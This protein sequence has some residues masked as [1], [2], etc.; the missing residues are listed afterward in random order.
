MDGHAESAP[1][2][3]G[4]AD[5][6]SFLSD[7]P[8]EESNEELEAPN[9]DEPTAESDQGEPESAG[10]DEAE[11]GG[12]EPADEAEEDA[13]PATER[14]IAVTIKADDGTETTQEV[15]ESELVKGYQ[16]QAD[17]T[18][19][20]QALAERESQAVEF[21]KTKHDEVR[22]HYM[23]QAEV[24]RAAVVQMAGIKTESEM[25]QLA[26]T[27]PAA[28]VAES[29]RQKAITTYLSQLDQQING[30]KQAAQQ[31]QS[32]RQLQQRQQAYQKAWTELSQDGIDK[33]KLASIYAKSEKLYGF[34]PAELA[35]VYDARMVRVLKD[36]AAFRDL[37]SQKKAVTQKVQEAPKLQA[38]KQ[39]P[40]QERRQQE[41]DNRFR[42]G[43]AKLSDLAA[44]LT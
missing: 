20:T 3:G 25:A 14:K 35:E 44:Y 19:K 27:D 5:L 30:E 9:S 32:Q 42:S 40:A 36:A 33:P 39:A 23:Q 13:D 37:Q 11:E 18:R 29:Q 15:A 26:Q 43:K 41:L 1:E 22:S 31:E 12:D 21:L 24:T 10:Q 17:Y 7:T 34:T 16:R 6:A 4:L 8:E 38:R 28:W 2:A